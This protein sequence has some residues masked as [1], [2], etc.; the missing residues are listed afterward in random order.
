MIDKSIRK[1]KKQGKK[2]SVPRALL[3]D[4]FALIIF[5]IIPLIYVPGVLDGV[6]PVRMLTISLFLVAFG[7]LL[8]LG[9]HLK[10]FPANIWNNPLVWL[11]LAYLLITTGSTAIALN[12]KETFFDIAR[13]LTF[14]VFTLFLVA[15]FCGT[16]DW[17]RRIVKFIIPAAI[18]SVMVGVY[19]LFKYV[20]GA[21]TDFLPDGRPIIYEVRGLMAHKNQYS[22]NL[23]LMLPMLV[24]G[25][26]VLENKIWR[27]LSLTAIL[28]VSIMIIILQTRSVWTA[29]LVTTF[30]LLIFAAIFSNKIGMS[31]KKRNV[32][33]ISVF[34][35]IALLMSIVVF[36][37]AQNE[38][39]RLAQLKSIA[40]P[41]AGNNEYRLK[42]WNVTT[43]MIA[44]FPLTGVGAGNWKLYAADYYAGHNLNE[45]QLN[46]IRPHNDFLWIFAEKGIAGIIVYTGIFLLT[47]FY[48]II[49]FFRTNKQKTRLLSMLIAGGLICY[50]ITSLFSFP[51]ERINQQIYLHL[52]TAAAIVLY[53]KTNQATSYK[54]LLNSKISFILIIALL[55][56]IIYS[57]AI[58]R[59][60]KWLAKARI[61]L[62]REAWKNLL[63]EVNNADTWTR[64]LDPEANPLDWYKGLA[65][66]GLNDHANALEAYKN[67]LK[68]HPN[69]IIV[70][71]NI[72]IIYSKLGDNENA[73]F[74]LNKALEI[75]PSYKPSLLAMATLYVEDENYPETLEML[76]RIRAK[77]KDETVTQNLQFVR[78]AILDQVLA[79][80]FSMQELGRTGDAR[81][82][83]DSATRIYHSADR[84]LEV[85]ESNYSMQIDKETLLEIL[86]MVPHEKR[87]ESFRQRIGQLKLEIDDE[88]K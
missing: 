68:A 8:Y 28:A 53:I 23:M 35:T 63:F 62:Q 37:P 29:L 76:E 46:W 2:D 3:F 10:S 16:E 70:L 9:G 36:V 65:H 83:F 43:E 59:S 11:L 49:A 24:Y 44:D 75:V 18:I 1:K 12:V 80:A 14:F 6:Q 50:H 27:R 88:G 21:E 87:S 38:F 33:L 85:L 34:T 58:L 17:E 79:E 42:I 26:K 54:K 60:D 73:K 72:G 77:Q 22:I 4:L 15:L 5:I 32:I 81:Q 66:S 82:L 52:F 13:T 39:S 51:L 78:K 47:I 20:I 61:S 57:S 55:F 41:D 67:A 48:L 19:Q 56:P 86:K 45:K 69:K 74:Y 7:G 84:F 71:H 25:L 30:I 64:N 40:N 31:A